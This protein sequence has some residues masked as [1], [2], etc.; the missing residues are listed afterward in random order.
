MQPGGEKVIG[1]FNGD[2]LPDILAPAQSSPFGA[3]EGYKLWVNTGKGFADRG[4]V[5]PGSVGTGAFLRA[6]VFDYDGDGR[7][8]ALLPAR[9]LNGVDTWFFISFKEWDEVVSG[10][11]EDVPPIEANPN[12]EMKKLK[13]QAHL[14]DP[15]GDGVPDVLIVDKTNHVHL[16]L[17]NG[18][19]NLVRSIQDGL[20]KL[21]QVQYNVDDMDGVYTPSVG[22][23]TDQT[24]IQDAYCLPRPIRPLIAGYSTTSEPVHL[25]QYFDERI[26]RHGRGLL[27]FGKV[28]D[29]T[30]L[31]ERTTEYDNR[32]YDA[33]RRVH[34]RAGLPATVSVRTI[35][36]GSPL[37]SNQDVYH[38]SREDRLYEVRGDASVFTVQLQHSTVQRFESLDACENDPSC[39]GDPLTST[40]SEYGYDDYGNITSEQHDTDGQIHRTL[41]HTFDP[42]A[43]EILDWLVGLKKREEVTEDLGSFFGAQTNVTTMTYYPGTD[44]LEHVFTEPDAQDPQ[45]WLKTSYVP[46]GFGNVHEVQRE[47]L[48][49]EVRGEVTQYDPQ[50]LMPVSFTDAVGLTTELLFEQ[51]YGKPRWL[52]DANHLKASWSYDAFGRLAGYQDDAGKSITR[53]YSTPVD[54]PTGPIQIEPEVQLTTTATG[55]PRLVAYLDEHGRQIGNQETGLNGDLVSV[56][57]EYNEFGWLVRESRP[58]KNGQMTQSVVQYDYDLLHRLR[59]VRNADQ[60]VRR[61]DFATA[62]SYTG[63]NAWFTGVLPLD[64]V[65]TTDE[66]GQVDRSMY[67]VRGAEIASIDGLNHQT[68]YIRGPHGRLTG[69]VDAIGQGTSYLYDSLDRVTDATYPEQG[70]W[71]YTYN[72]FGELGTRTSPQDGTSIF[73]FDA[74]GRPLSRRDPGQQP[75]TWTWDGTG[76]NQQGRLTRTQSPDG[77]SVDF[78]YDSHGLIHKIT[79]TLLGEPMVLTVDRDPVGRISQIHYPA[80]DLPSVGNT[81]L[82]VE[83]VY[84]GFGHVSLVRDAVTHARYW[85]A[86]HTDDAGRVDRIAWQRGSLDPLLQPVEGMA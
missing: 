32:S 15:N 86:R 71:S 37:T 58:H 1:D 46:D 74:V 5:A 50:G 83:N 29:D 11:A 26:D 27:G 44:A 34:L 57:R 73:D 16:S 30:P 28:T 17:R 41:T 63:S 24:C 70:H 66:A 38:L 8:D 33:I 2:G 72:A 6:L 51:R 35:T 69:A 19:R 39:Y 55:G 65:E 43:P 13:G 59:L 42:T 67:D 80:S 49:G 85:E 53:T 75:A 77:T 64:L 20:G 18:N 84:D 25:Y 31:Y 56:E 23:D 76:L 81:G 40:E 12:N 79:Q 4:E 22:A 61:T 21:T 47:D 48:S 3:Y 68:I 54:V 60:S 14:V 36:D 62:R 10:F 7:D 9:D 78:E 52:S 45:T 82:T